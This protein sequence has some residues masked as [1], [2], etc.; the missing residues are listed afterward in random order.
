M[1]SLLDWFRRPEGKRRLVEELK[2]QPLVQAQ[3]DL[4]ED[5]ARD[6]RLERVRSGTLLIG[7]GAPD[8]D[9]F[10][11]LRGK[12]SV[13]STGARSPGSAPAIIWGDMA[14]LTKSRR[15]TSATAIADSVVARIGKGEFFALA[16]RFPDLWRRVAAQLAIRLINSG[17][18]EEP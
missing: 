14:A 2:A 3:D 11:I 18:Q 9:I 6:V 13:A 4:A 16:G 17:V 10:L 5:I 12:F 1:E 7:Q 15:W 8:N